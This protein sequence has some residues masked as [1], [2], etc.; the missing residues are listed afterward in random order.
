MK[1]PI[2]LQSFYDILKMNNDE[3]IK[4]FISS[5]DDNIHVSSK[6]VK[7]NKEELLTFE[8]F[9]DNLEE[10]NE[11]QKS[12]FYYG[13]KNDKV[14]NQE[15]DL[16]RFCQNTIVNIELK[17]ELPPKGLEGIC[18]SL[19]RQNHILINCNKSVFNYVFIMSEN[20][21][22]KLITD[23]N[24]GKEQLRK[25]QFNDLSENLV[26][27]YLDVNL[28]ESLTTEDLIISPYSSPEKFKEKKFFLNEEQQE[29]VNLILENTSEKYHAIYGGAG[30]GKSLLLL[31]IAEEFIKRG[32]KVIVFSV[33]N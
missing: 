31:Q 18:E 6:N 33:E 23:E 30:T 25:V 11:F 12:G 7:L 5:L 29:I 17:S 14:I 22:Y 27:D 15:F 3:I 20:Q 19:K 32:Q 21:L 28:L 2:N 4:L 13:Y 24:E 1:K 10:F 9:Y 26:D 16:L 8:S